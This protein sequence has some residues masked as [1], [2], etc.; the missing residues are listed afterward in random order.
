M[1]ATKSAHLDRIRA[2]ASGKWSFIISTIGRIPAELLDGR[3]HPCPS[4]KCRSQM[5]AFRAFNDFDKSGGTV[6]NQCGK[7]GD[8]FA[9]LEWLTG[10]RFPEVVELIGSLLGI[11][12]DAG[13]QSVDPAYHL[14]WIDWNDSLAAMWCLRY[15]PVIPEAIKLAGGRMAIYR[16]KHTVIALPVWLGTRTNIVGWRIWNIRGKLP[17]FNKEDPKKVEWVKSKLTYGSQPGVVGVVPSKATEIWKVEGETDMLALLSINPR[18][19]VVCNA[20]GAGELPV[21]FNWLREAIGKIANFYVLHDADQPGQEGAEK[22]TKHFSA[23]LGGKV[24]V[25]NVELPYPIDASKGKD[26]RDWLG[27]GNQYSALL[28][29][30]AKFA[31]SQSIG[32]LLPEESE[33]DPHRLARVNLEHYER[34]HDGRLVYWRDEWWKYKAGYYRQIASG[35]LRAKITASIRKE[36][37]NCWRARQDKGGDEAKQPVRKVTKPLVG[38]VIGAME[39]MVARSGNV[40]MPCWLPDRRPRNYLSM[41]NGILDLDAL[42][43][44]AELE[45]CLLPHSPHWFT[46]FR[47]N[48]QFDPDATCPRWLDYLDFVSG[49]DAEKKQLMQEWAG[50]LLW[51]ASEEQKFLVFEG[52]GN[53]GKS[54]FF[55][56]IEAMLGSENVSSLSLE[57]FKETFALSSTVGKVANIAG[58]VGKIEGGEEAIL[59][60]YTGGEA[61]QIRRMY[62]PPLTVRPTA[63]LMMAWND[64]PKFMDKSEGLWRRM[65]LIPL[66]ETVHRDKRIKGMDRPAFWESEAPGIMIWALA[67][68]ERLIRQGDFSRC[69]AADEALSEYKTDSNPVLQFFSDYVSESQNSG[70]PSKQLYEFYRHWCDKEGYRSMSDRSFGRQIKKFIPSCSKIKFR[71]GKKLLWRYEGICWSV[72][73]IFG[74]A[75][76]PGELF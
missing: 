9:T 47:L 45:Q 31:E 33:D 24:H 41:A 71:E 70:I 57:N 19:A 42:F 1:Q 65:I 55:A 46:S 59:K 5:D 18:A 56:G 38:N 44:D 2:A 4:G 8:G 63:K 58:D 60:R 12:R 74:K 53:N 52:E 64:R 73:E 50:Y 27:E 49:G 7:H 48:Y 37:E 21:K 66:T 68:L 35:E 61:L 54:S 62:L 20:N 40:T 14:R 25:A 51:P 17:K 32:L 10:R 16:G 13:R 29:R 67:G 23:I 15:K 39:S 28:Q 22:W 75:V 43:A 6:C 72:D 34:D 36:F 30:A 26:L 69:K 11:D 3:H 76:E